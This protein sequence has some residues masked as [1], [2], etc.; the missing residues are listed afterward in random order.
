LFNG[1][2]QHKRPSRRF[3]GRYRLE[4]LFRVEIQIYLPRLKLG[5]HFGQGIFHL[6]FAHPDFRAGHLESRRQVEKTLVKA[7][8]ILTR[9]IEQRFAEFASNAA[10]G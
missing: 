10:D 4:Q 8:R 6:R 9:E 3:A 2:I 1:K 5:D 7:F